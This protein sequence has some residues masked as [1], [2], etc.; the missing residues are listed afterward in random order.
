MSELYIYSNDEPI[1]END[2]PIS[3]NNEEILDYYDSDESVAKESTVEPCSLLR[4]ELIDKITPLLNKFTED[5]YHS[6]NANAMELFFL[7][8]SENETKV[9]KLNFKISE[10]ENQLS[11]NSKTSKLEIDNYVEQI[12]HI[13]DSSNN[14]SLK[15]DTLKTKYDTNSQKYQ[16]DIDTFIDQNYELQR[17]QIKLEKNIKSLETQLDISTNL[18][19]ET[20]SKFSLFEQLDKKNETQIKEYQ[21]MIENHKQYILDLERTH[22]KDKT[23]VVRY[24]R[25]EAET[26]TNNLTK[27]VNS[28]EEKCTEYETTISELKQKLDYMNESNCQFKSCEKYYQN[29]H[30]DI[31]I[32]NQTLTETKKELLNKLEVQTIENLNLKEQLGYTNLNILS[33]AA[34]VTELETP[35]K[36][37]KTKPQSQPQPSQTPNTRYNLRTRNT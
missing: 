1:S 7:E 20:E 14:I 8:Q 37:K 5:T 19:N 34:K 26:L 30:S 11:D 29:R 35:N 4:D 3:E 2:E 6:L 18:L 17:T 16:D 15:Y 10:L 36:S 32:E 13:N 25:I 9:N 27:Q 28:M 21:S 33:L 24:V 22:Q 31:S 23:D 12:N